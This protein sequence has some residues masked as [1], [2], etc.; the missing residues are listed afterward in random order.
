MNSAPT[1]VSGRTDCRSASHR[2]DPRGRP[3]RQRSR[4]SC[5]R[6]LSSRSSTGFP[7]AWPTT[8][9]VAC[10][11]APRSR[12]RGNAK[13]LYWVFSRVSH[14]FSESV[15][16]MSSAASYGVG[17]SPSSSRTGTRRNSLARCTW[18][19]NCST[20]AS[21]SGPAAASAA[22]TT[23][24]GIT[25]RLTRYRSINCCIRWKTA[26]AASLSALSRQTSR[27]IARALPPWALRPVNRLPLAPPH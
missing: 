25:G 17:P 19:T 27:A 18:W 7:S 12:E 15:R 1:N 21:I 6:I 9:A 11:I 2:V 8:V 23:T 16:T 13:F 4:L 26:E 22:W 5:S 10:S 20:R 14:G 3:D 24:S